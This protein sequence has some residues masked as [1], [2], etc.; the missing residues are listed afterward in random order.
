MVYIKSQVPGDTGGSSSGI[1]SDWYTQWH[2]TPTT[3][4]E[5]PDPT[6]FSFVSSPDAVERRAAAIAKGDGTGS[7]AAP[8]NTPSKETSINQIVF[9]EQTM[10]EEAFTDLIL[11]EIGNREL[12][13]I[14]RHDSLTGMTAPKYSPIKNISSVLFSNSPINIAPNPNSTI[15]YFDT[16]AILLSS[17]LPTDAEIDALDSSYKKSYVY[18]EPSNNS[19]IINTANVFNNEGV[20]IEFVTFS[21]LNDDTIYT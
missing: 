3:P 15:D 6:P 2:T 10:T 17:Y 9:N 20:E 4:A 7:P 12:L 5:K 16:F 11:D 19:V 13:T 14:A 21:S 8:V 1:P 18:Y